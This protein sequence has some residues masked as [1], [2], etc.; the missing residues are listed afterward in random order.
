MT[1]VTP[2]LSAMI[3]PAVLI[4]GAGTL[5]MSTSARVGRATDRLRTITA[6]FKELT[7][8]QAEHEPL[9]ADE[10]HMLMEQL[11]RLARRIR[12]LQRAMITFYLAVGTL[13]TTSILIG[14]DALI[15]L[16]T[17]PLPVLFALGGSA[18]LAYGA[19][20]LSYEAR[21]SAVTTR[22]EM[23]FL[24][25]LGTHYAQLSGELKAGETLGG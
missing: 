7:G 21:L 17:G 2:V 24:R 14:M 22:D 19:L 18:A 6:R 13:V 16:S 15:G 9:A 11:P 8:P 4:S 20:L 5:L 3:T 10:R 25:R 12:Y 1:E 23:A